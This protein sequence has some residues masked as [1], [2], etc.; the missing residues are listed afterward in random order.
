MK[1]AIFINALILTAFICA[2]PAFA[3]SADVSKIENFL[4]NIINIFSILAGT[5]AAGFMVF[6]GFKYI[7]SSD[8]PESLDGAKKTIVNS[9][10]GLAIV[11]GA[12]VIMQIVSQAASSAFGGSS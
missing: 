8:N 11:I 12:F 6:G 9:L 4:K 3:Q 2:T 1:K 5:V 10:I 7:T